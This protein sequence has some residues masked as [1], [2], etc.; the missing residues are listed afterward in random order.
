M[1][2]I[3]LVA[4]VDPQAIGGIV[5]R[6]FDP[7]YGEGWSAAQLAGTLALA[8]SWARLALAAG[9][10]VGF[11]LCRQAAGEAELLLVGVDPAFRQCGIGAMLV[12]AAQ[13]DAYAYG[14]LALF[15]EVRDGN[16]AA[17][18]LYEKAGFRVVGRRRDYYLGLSSE[19]FDALTMRNILDPATALS[20]LAKQR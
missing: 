14:A 8:G 7:R 16:H 19:R 3:E 9:T 15:L 20:G 6:A 13:R 5:G 4:T 1:T 11:S 2:G 12:A 17:R 18:L 10:P